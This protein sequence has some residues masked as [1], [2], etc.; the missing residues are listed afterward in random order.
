MW[1]T[2]PF[3]KRR[4]PF[5]VTTVHRINIHSNH[6]PAANITN[7][8][9]S[10]LYERL[11]IAVQHRKR[12]IVVDLD[13]IR[14]PLV[15]CRPGRNGTSSI[16]DEARERIAT[17][18]CYC[19]TLWDC[20]MRTLLDRPNNRKWRGTQP[21]QVIGG[22]WK[23]RYV[24]SPWSQKVAFRDSEPGTLP[25]Y[26]N[27]RI[28]YGSFTVPILMSGELV[29]CAKFCSG[30][31]LTIGF[32]GLKSMDPFPWLLA[33][34][35]DWHWWSQTFIHGSHPYQIYNIY[36]FLLKI[37]LFKGEIIHARRGRRSRLIGTFHIWPS[38]DE[39]QSY[40]SEDY[41]K[42]RVV[43]ISTD[44]FH[45]FISNYTISLQALCQISLS[46]SRGL[47]GWFVNPLPVIFVMI[48]DIG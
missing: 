20:V 37:Q 35:P 30:S 19:I 46:I 23:G 6:P 18:S 4:I 28:F 15:P 14:W 26:R 2:V 3:Y 24:T 48:S 7:I 27:S 1:Q 10:I 41:L 9:A 43:Y 39:N 22:G 36:L 40:L 11:V 45:S 32:P 31:K 44:I 21:T 12:W 29:Q 33:D 42:H 38:Y 17:L 8:A 16:A 25:N 13:F 5:A 47:D 34:I